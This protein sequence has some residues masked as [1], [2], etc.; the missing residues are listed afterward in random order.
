[1]QMGDAGKT[2]YCI[3]SAG[4]AI[5]ITDAPSSNEITITE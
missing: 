2:L 5:G 3:V 4:N 1:V